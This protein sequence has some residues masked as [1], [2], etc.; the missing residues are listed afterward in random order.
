MSTLNLSNNS[1]VLQ[2]INLKN[3]YNIAK[4]LSHNNIEDWDLL[5]L[6]FLSIKKED[7]F[8]F[9]L[10]FLDLSDDDYNDWINISKNLERQ[11]L[12]GSFKYNIKM[13]EIIKIIGT[14][15]VK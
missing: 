5:E 7:K 10:K 11:I 9:F 1:L 3:I 8:N 2:P 13:K 6:N 4:S 15:N 12:Y 14:T